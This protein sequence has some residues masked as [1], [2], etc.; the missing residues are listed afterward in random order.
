M[1][2]VFHSGT[3]RSFPPLPVEPH[4]RSRGELDIAT[5][6]GDEFGDARSGV[7]EGCEEHAVTPT[8]PSGLIGC[9]NQSVDFHP[10][11]EA[12]H[13]LRE[14]LRRDGQHSLHEWQRDRIPE[15][16]VAHERPDRGEA[17]ITTASRVV[18]GV[19]QVVEKRQDHRSVLVAE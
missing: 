3:V 15:R 5:T 8:A 18:P 4:G 7:V 16:R 6:E 13:G 19:L 9:A 10:R 14:P 17:Q 12:E 11:Q 1:A 2:V